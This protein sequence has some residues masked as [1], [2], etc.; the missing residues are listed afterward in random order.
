MKRNAFLVG[1]FVLLAL[2]LAVAG[3]VTI[4]KSGWFSTRQQAVVNFSNSVKGLYVGAP[5][6][7][8]GVKMGEVTQI[9]VEVNQATLVTRI[10]VTLTLSMDSLQMDTGTGNGKSIDIP[11]LV[12][13]G[14]RARLFLQSVVTNQ[15]AVELDFRPDLPGPLLADKGD[16]L[17]EIPT[18]TDK[19]D[20]LLNQV[21]DLPL[22]EM[23]NEL[24][25]TMKTLNSALTTSQTAIEHTSTQLEA[26]GVQARQTLASADKALQ[27]VQS[28]TTATLRS[29]QQLSETTNGVVSQAQPALQQALQETQK[30]AE[31]ARV[32]MQ[33]LADVTAPGSP[34]RADVHSAVSDLSHAARSLR[35]FAD[36]VERQ[37]NSVIFGDKQ[38]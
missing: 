23:V 35:T 21:Q 1:A 6:T 31:S 10:P 18:M 24:R 27:A 11:E 7:F 3:V 29:L 25:Q 12:R 19:L 5:V 15:T 33:S 13:R 34:L 20:A 14:L 9:D 32:A 37:P 22:A 17:P 4:N 30:A 16:T 36:Q 28:Q 38:P 26:T 2:L 8:R